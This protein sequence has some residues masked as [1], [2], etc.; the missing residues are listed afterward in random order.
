MNLQTFLVSVGAMALVVSVLLAGE[1][2]R[3]EK[4]QTEVRPVRA[5]LLSTVVKEWIPGRGNWNAFGTFAVVAD[6]FHGEA[7]GSLRPASFLRG[8]GRRY[9]VKRAEAEGFLP[10]WVVGETYDAFQYPDHRSSVFFQRPDAE[11][12]GRQVLWMRIVGVLLVAGGLV[13]GYRR[14]QLRAQPTGAG[15]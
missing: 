7:E 8:K 9:K 3:L 14:A 5:T 4:L 11:G 2:E 1:H 12:V 10:G 15:L 6:D 13:L